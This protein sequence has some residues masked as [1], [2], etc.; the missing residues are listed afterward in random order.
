MAEFFG[1]DIKLYL[2]PGATTTSLIGA[3]RDING[4]NIDDSVIDVSSRDSGKQ[5]ARL[6]GL[7]SGGEL[8]FDLVYDP[9]ATTHAALS[10]ALTDGTTC[11]MFLVIDDL[12]ERGWYGTCIVSAFSPKAPLGDK[13]AADVTLTMLGAMAETG[14]LSPAGSTDYIVT[15]S[16]GDYLIV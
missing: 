1:G 11:T 3:V 14:Y 4:P 2:N 16:G 13:F 6:S 7:R 12:T 8:T 10:T 9:D 5:R 15:A